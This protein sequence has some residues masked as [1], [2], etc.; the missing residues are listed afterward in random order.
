MASKPGENM[1]IVG[2]LCLMFGLLGGITGYSMKPRDETIMLIGIAL[3]AL[4]L[5]LF[6]AG[7]LTKQKR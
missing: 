2:G 1:R 7:A 5:V 3:G 4:G 6:I